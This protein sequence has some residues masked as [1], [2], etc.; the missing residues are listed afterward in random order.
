MQL[1]ITPQVADILQQ[2]EK[3]SVNEK[4][5]LFWLMLHTFGQEKYFDYKTIDIP[6]GLVYILTYFENNSVEIKNN[7]AIKFGLLKDKIVVPKDFDEPLE[8]LNEYMY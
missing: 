6:N 1:Q 8:D 5:N 3:M 7:N 4:Q 2:T